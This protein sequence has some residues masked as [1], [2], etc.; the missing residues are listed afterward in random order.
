M[1]TPAGVPVAITSPGYRVMPR[2][3]VS[4]SVG[5]SKISCEVRACWRTS[6]LT[7]QT[8]SRSVPSTS[9]ALTSHGPIGQKVSKD[10]PRSHC[11]WRICTSRAVTSLTMV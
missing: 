3:Q 10:L 4:I 5:M 7:R 11:E 9:S 6:P 8:S 2:E 1:P